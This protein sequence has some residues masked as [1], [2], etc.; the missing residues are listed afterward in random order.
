V[1]FHGDNTGIQLTTDA[2]KDS[3]KERFTSP[4][5]LFKLH[6]AV[7]MSEEAI[8]ESCKAV[9]EYLTTSGIK[10][11]IV[12]KVS[13]LL[14]G[15]DYKSTLEKAEMYAGCRPFMD[16]DK[17]LELYTAAWET[18]QKSLFSEKVRL[19]RK[20]KEIAADGKADDEAIAKAT[21]AFDAA[22]MALAEAN[23][24]CARLRVQ[25]NIGKPEAAEAAAP[26]VE[27]A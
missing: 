3:S 7:S 15:G 19:L 12:A 26:E 17:F 14:V 10:D 27:Q 22:E 23:V 8:Q 1:P 13:S 5:T 21:A 24:M 20:K 2:R 25:G 11:D 4:L 16:H 6:I 18:L 9:V